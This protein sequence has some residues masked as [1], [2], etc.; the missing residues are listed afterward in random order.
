MKNLLSFTLLLFINTLFAQE[1]SYQLIVKVQGVESQ[2]G[3]VFVALFDSEQNFL[4]KSLLGSS[5]PIDGN[6]L[7]FT[8]SEVKEGTYAISIFHDVNSNKKL[9]SN[10]MGI[11][12]EPY[13]FSNNAKGMFGPPKFEECKFEIIGSNKELTIN[14]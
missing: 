2:E 1:P 9:D 6:T 10:F 8:F 4:G 7:T 13:G 11:P 3:Q 12:S 14:L 5:K